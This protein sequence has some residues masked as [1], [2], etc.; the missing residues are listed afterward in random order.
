MNS[1]SS[2]DVLK[3]FLRFKRCL[4]NEHS[5]M[6]LARPPKRQ[7]TVTSCMIS[8]E[9]EK[10]VWENDVNED[11][12]DELTTCK[13]KAKR[14]A[15]VHNVPPSP[16]VHVRRL[17]ETAVE[18]DL[19]Q[20]LERFGIISYVLMLPLKRQA[21]VEFSSIESA[22]RCVSHALRECVCVA[23]RPAFFNYSESKKIIRP[24]NT[25]SHDDG[26]RVLLLF[27][28]NAHYP[29]T[30]DVLYNVCN[31]I[32]K[33]LR[34]VIFKRNG[35]LAMV[36]F[37]T[38]LGAQRAKA[39]LNGADIYSNCCTMKIE[40]AKPTHLNVVKNDAESWDYTKP[41]LGNGDRVNQRKRKSILG[42]HP[43]FLSEN[44]HCGQTD[45]S[46]YRLLGPHRRSPDISEVTYPLP[47]NSFHAGP[48]HSP[49]IMV[50]GLHHK[51]NCSRIFNLFCLYGNVRKV[52]FMRSVPG[53]ALVEMG[54]TLGV[55]RVITHLNNIKVF[56]KKFCLCASKK[57]TVIPGDTYLLDDGSSS[58]QDFGMTRNNR[59]TS[60]AMVSKTIIQSPSSVLHYY[61]APPSVTHDDLQKLCSDHDLPV[62]VR[63]RAFTK[64]SSKTNSG[65]LEFA[66]QNE[67]VEV[68]MVLNNHQ[69]RI[70]NY[71]QPFTLKLC[72]ST[73]SHL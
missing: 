31:P 40:Y 22:E 59:F 58:F 64:A 14:Q 55:D 35:L 46:S 7:K 48:S 44:G 10:N 36:E 12:L 33:V 66:S 28:Q 18:A 72:F 1:F 6:N 17:C 20:A 27:I 62:F 49:V 15:D 25:V 51:M 71:T 69:I 43:S 21:L 41:H 56:G 3:N 60:S 24:E 19:V 50:S 37:E 16:V 68:L 45:E 61:N 30:T 34:I 23:G 9:R 70:E 67:A 13:S 65:L 39:E 8:D 2:Q 47:I 5:D 26:N 54:D 52:K 29:I 11:A 57:E 32:G 4:S 38:P 63:Y 53:C 73:T 42:D